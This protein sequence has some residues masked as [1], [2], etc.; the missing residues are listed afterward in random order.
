M[1]VC[2]SVCLSVSVSVCLSVGVLVQA[3]SISFRIRRRNLL[4]THA[5]KKIQLGQ[6]REVRSNR[7]TYV[8]YAPAR[9]LETTSAGRAQTT[10]EYSVYSARNFARKQVKF[11]WLDT[12]AGCQLSCRV[13]HA[14]SGGTKKSTDSGWNTCTCIGVY[15]KNSF[16]RAMGLRRF[17][18]SRRHTC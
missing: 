15:L 8:V 16:G 12:F 18:Q 13:C 11:A 6:Q 3:R 17:M 1:C 7:R 5:K 14:T 9:E 4:A 10:A 2:L